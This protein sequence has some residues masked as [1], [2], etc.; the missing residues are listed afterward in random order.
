MLKCFCRGAK[1]TQKLETKPKTYHISISTLSYLIKKKKVTQSLS[2]FLSSSSLY[3]L[4]PHLSVCKLS[5]YSNHDF[6]TILNKYINNLLMK[7]NSHI[8]VLI[9]F[10]S[11]QHLIMLTSYSCKCCPSGASITAHCP[12]IP[13]INRPLLT[14]PCWRLLLLC[15]SLEYMWLFR[16]PSSILFSTKFPSVTST[17]FNFRLPTRYWWLPKVQASLLSAR[18]T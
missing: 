10:L 8:S 2:L 11:I 13:L 5:L 16:I 6:E 9:S 17:I 12:G 1:K 15:P 18:V 7:Y 14:C 4:L 3:S